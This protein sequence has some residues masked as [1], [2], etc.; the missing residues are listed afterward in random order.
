MKTK[1]I[2]IL[3]ALI[4]NIGVLIYLIQSN[5]N[6]E[7]KLDIATQNMMAKQDSV[8]ME[9]ENGMRVF[10]RYSGAFDKIDDIEKALPNLYNAVDKLKNKKN[11][12]NAT[13]I[14]NVYSDTSKK[15]LPTIVEKI[16]SNTYKFKWEYK[17]STRTLAGETTVDIEK[18]IISQAVNGDTALYYGEK[19]INITPKGTNITNDQLKLSLL[20]GVRREGK[21][22]RIFVVPDDPN[23]TVTDIEGAVYK[24]KE[25][26]WGLSGYSGYGVQYDPINKQISSGIQVGVGVTYT[27]LRW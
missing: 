25:K 13:Y 21:H 19:I 22:D 27:F 16:D 1:N 26:K 7:R 17:D 5:N 4:A 3:G 20:V 15:D 9:I 24:R 23:V 12:T 11:I 6:T 2:L 14:T 10:S 8:S 18:Q